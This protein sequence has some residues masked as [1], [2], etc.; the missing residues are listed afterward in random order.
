MTMVCL[1]T[2]SLLG[3][4]SVR[5]KLLIPAGS[6]TPLFGA[7]KEQTAVGVASFH[8]DSHPV[9]VADFQKFLAAQPQWLHS[10]KTSG[11]TDEAARAFWSNREGLLAKADQPAVRVSWFAA[12]A[13]C[14]S[15]LG[16]LPTTMEW[17]YVAIADERT[18][19]AALDPAFNAKI[20]A[21]YATPNGREELSSVYQGAPNAYGLYHIH[22]LIWEWTDDFNGFFAAIDSRQNNDKNSDLFCGSGALGAGNRQD[23]AAFMR[24]A[25]R[26]S[27]KARDSLANLGFRCAYD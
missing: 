25:L 10:E 8:L 17:E 18:R 7:G 26:S 22:G 20:L 15:M 19:D 23:Y 1:W 4:G 6:F 11:Q 2:T 13:Y 3:A 16:R 12:A 9:T 5:A 21:W 27:L 14:E 24:F